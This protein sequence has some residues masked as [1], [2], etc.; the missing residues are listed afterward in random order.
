MVLAYNQTGQN[1]PSNKNLH[2]VVQY[3]QGLHERIKNTCKKYGEQVYFKG[4]QTIK[5]LLM[6]PK[7][8]DPITNRSGVIYRYK[9]SKDGCEEEYI[10]ESTRT[11]AG[12][13]QRTSEVP[14]SNP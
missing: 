7:D 11:F 8:K 1:K 9:C 5:G 13:V 14:L 3:Q 12:E 6:A 10:G 4:G 2:M